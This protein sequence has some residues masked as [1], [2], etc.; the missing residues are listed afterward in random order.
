MFEFP[1]SE[2]EGALKVKVPVYGYEH[3]QLGLVVWSKL[4]LVAGMQLSGGVEY[5]ELDSVGIS[6]Y[7]A[8]ASGSIQIGLP[9]SL[10][11]ITNAFSSR[12]VQAIRWIISVYHV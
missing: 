12:L 4:Q 9:M 2:K 10:K 6:Q 8:V 1:R 11:K 5:E 7:V 3:L